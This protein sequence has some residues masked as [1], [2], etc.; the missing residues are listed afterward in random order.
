M[1]EDFYNILEDAP[2]NIWDD[3]EWSPF[4][5][6]CQQSVDYS[7]VFVVRMNIYIYIYIYIYISIVDVDLEG[8]Y[9][10]MLEIFGCKYMYRNKERNEKVKKEIDFG[11][12]LAP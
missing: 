9:V 1:K 4:I 7:I 10:K 12:A 8:I 5:F 2:Y 6:Y 11:F 3:Q